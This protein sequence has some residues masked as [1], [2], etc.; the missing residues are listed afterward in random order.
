MLGLR[1]LWVLYFRRPRRLAINQAY[2]SFSPPRSF[3]PF[4][5][6]AEGHVPQDWL[7]HLET[8]QMHF[9]AAAQYRKSVDD[10]EANRWARP[11]ST[12]D[13]DCFTSFPTGTEKRS[14]V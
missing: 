14:P 2:L 7:P 4:F 8:K 10:L 1:L 5:Q 12:D 13:N 3:L 11:A 6:R 9:E